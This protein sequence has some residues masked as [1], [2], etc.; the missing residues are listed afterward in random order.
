MMKSN[1][2][3][4]PSY[5]ALLIFIFLAMISSAAA[6]QPSDKSKYHLFH[7]T[8]DHLLRDLSTDRPDLTESPYTV[9][10]GHFQIETDF[11]NASFDH[12]KS[13]GGD[14]Y[15]RSET[16]GGINFKIGLL[17]QVD[18]QTV[19]NVHVIDTSK[20][21]ITGA[22]TREQGF[23]DI[24]TRL[25]INLWGNDQGRTALGIM[26]FLKY[27]LSASGL[28]N[29]KT[30][31]GIILPFSMDAGKGWGLGAQ[32]EVDFVSDGAGGHDAEYFNTVTIG[33]DIIGN[34]AGYTEFAALLTPENSVDWQG[35]WNVGF[36]YAI[37][38][39]TQ[40]DCGC[41]FGVTDSAPDYNP[42]FGMS[43][44]Y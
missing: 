33:H 23:G 2:N 32:T 40:L 10:A 41:N 24:T 9:D 27:P 8:P 6:D 34:L 3:L 17:N 35:F 37:N 11:V 44:R 31:G 4:H 7:P 28:R 36:T 43:F 20:N 21:R 39:N 19:F 22:K 13:G 12:D 25:K 5:R 38:A 26:P 14:V 1:K 15:S 16:Y 18:L 30:E 29:G 42:F